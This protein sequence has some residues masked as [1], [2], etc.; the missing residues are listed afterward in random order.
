MDAST[1][2]IGSAS[3][4]GL[5]MTADYLLANLPRISQTRS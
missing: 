2:V 4:I 3:L 5:Y 1:V